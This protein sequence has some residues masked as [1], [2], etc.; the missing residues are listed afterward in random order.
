MGIVAN[1][2]HKLRKLHVF[3]VEQSRYLGMMAIEQDGRTFL[4]SN[5][6]GISWMEL[7]D[8]TVNKREMH[9]YLLPVLFLVP[10]STFLLGSPFSRRGD[11]CAQKDGETLRGL[12]R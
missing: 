8:K 12:S 10:A 2:V 4:F 3:L 1:Q 5:G 6:A 7:K 11:P 9:T